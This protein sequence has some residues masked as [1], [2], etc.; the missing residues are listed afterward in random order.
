M[1][2]S[3]FR[4]KVAVQEIFFVDFIFFLKTP[5]QKPRRS[6]TKRPDEKPMSYGT[7]EGG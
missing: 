3:F 6:I 4:I 2:D 5:N 1:I 7:P